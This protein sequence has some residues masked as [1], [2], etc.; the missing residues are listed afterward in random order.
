[1][2]I[3]IVITSLL[4]SFD[5][6]PDPWNG[7]S[8]STSENLDSFTFNPAGVGINHGIESG[9]YFAPDANQVISKIIEYSTIPGTSRH[10][11]GTDLDIID[12]NSTYK[13]DV[14]VPSKFHGTGPFCKL[15]EWMDNNAAN[16]GFKLVYTDTPTREGFKYEPWHYSFAEI[17]K[18]ML[19]EYR[20]ID[21]K[22]FLKEVPQL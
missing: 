19:S 5:V 18:P 1:M 22:S 16:F 7:Y 17:S 14:L 20:N 11:W 15:K 4:F 2:H 6:D 10:H 21:L 8:V 12:A 9:Y 13:G 3:F